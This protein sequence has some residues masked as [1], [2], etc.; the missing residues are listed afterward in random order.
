MNDPVKAFGDTAVRLSRNP[1]GIIALFIVLV[2]GFASYVTNST[3]MTPAERMPLIY[4]LVFFP[5]IVLGVFAWLVSQHWRKLY[6]PGDYKDEHNYVTVVASLA[7]ATVKRP[8]GGTTQENVDVRAI[9]QTVQNFAPTNSA[10]A[11]AHRAHILWVDDNPD[12]N[13]YERQAFEA[14][15]VTFELARS[16]KQALKLLKENSFT[17]I[18]SDM[19]REEGPR[20]GYVLLDALRGTGDLTPFFIYAGSNSPA[21]KC[22]AA[23]HGG[24]GTTNRAQELFEMVMGTLIS[25]R[26]QA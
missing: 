16:T 2:Y 8:D 13:I 14:V 11:T 21:H 20:E 23:K 19:G 12:N 9:A 26:E 25:K 4:F 1:L 18:I 7:A 15:G 6:G 5:V 10:K 24:Q 22:E 3:N 17:A